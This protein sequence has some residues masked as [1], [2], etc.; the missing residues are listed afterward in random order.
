MAFV[1]RRPDAFKN[2]R[3]DPSLLT[4]LQGHQSSV[5]F[6]FSLPFMKARRVVPLGCKKSRRWFTKGLVLSVGSPQ[7]DQPGLLDDLWKVL[8]E[9]GVP[10]VTSMGPVLG[11]KIFRISA[12]AFDEVV[13][14]YEQGQKHHLSS[15]RHEVVDSVRGVDSVPTQQDF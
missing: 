14:S 11:I 15:D 5:R 4:H 7:P 3:V 12:D 2:F 6:V 10:H 8:S 9:S 1:L 13:R